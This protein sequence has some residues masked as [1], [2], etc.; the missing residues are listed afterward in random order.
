MDAV[1]GVL[2]GLVASA[3]SGLA[4]YWWKAK[5]DLNMAA[6]QCYDRL[7]KLQQAQGLPANERTKVIDDETFLLGVHMDLY[8]ASLAP[9]LLTRSRRR[10]YWKAYESMIAVLIMKDPTKLKDTIDD[11]APLVKAPTTAR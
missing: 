9:A 10:R 1:V 2:I 5:H 4:A 11:L 3:G 7:M 6:V 8:R